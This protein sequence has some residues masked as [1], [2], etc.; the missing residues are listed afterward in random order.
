MLP[1]FFIVRLLKQDVSLGMA[2]AIQLE[3]QRVG[4][5]WTLN[6]D[7]TAQGIMELPKIKVSDIVGTR[8]S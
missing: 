8:L 6:V 4:P 1:N 2:D 5:S 7:L 3:S